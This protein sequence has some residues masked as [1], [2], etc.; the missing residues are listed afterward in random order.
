MSA[1][2]MSIRASS[3]PIDSMIME[4]SVKD[5]RSTTES[6]G[7]GGGLDFSSSRVM[8]LVDVDSLHRLECELQRRSARVHRGRE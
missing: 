7:C 6:V 5:E 1:A 4:K 2:G 3:P 8:G